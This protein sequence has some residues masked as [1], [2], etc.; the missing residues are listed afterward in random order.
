VVSF[1]DHEGSGGTNINFFD[2]RMAMV[3]ICNKAVSVGD[4]NNIRHLCNEYFDLHMS[5]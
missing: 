1:G 5:A 3:L 2:G 4:L